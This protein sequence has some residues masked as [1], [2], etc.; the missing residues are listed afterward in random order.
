VDVYMHSPIRLHGVVLNKLNTGT[1]LPYLYF[2][3]T[4]IW[5]NNTVVLIAV[6]E[7][8]IEGRWKQQF[9]RNP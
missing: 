9:P 2:A 1:T 3:F 4:N 6:E 7:L 5:E 8:K